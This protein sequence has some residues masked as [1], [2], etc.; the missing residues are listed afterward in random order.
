[1]GFLDRYRRLPFLE[2][3][4]QRF[5]ALELVSVIIIFMG[6]LTL[7]I[8][9]VYENSTGGMDEESYL[10]ILRVLSGFFIIII[11]LV[12]L[13]FF[14]YRH[15]SALETKLTDLKAPKEPKAYEGAIEGTEYVEKKEAEKEALEITHYPT[16]EEEKERK[17]REA[18]ALAQRIKHLEES[19]DEMDKTMTYKKCPM[20]GGLYTEEWDKCPKCDARLPK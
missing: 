12:I 11:G 3:E 16:E 19:F 9:L 10:R 14:M 7:L 5:L 6:C 17:T 20:C 18:K 4:K 15:V 13:L 2:P 1:M 8:T